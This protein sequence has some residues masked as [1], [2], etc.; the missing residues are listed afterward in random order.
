[1][2]LN[3]TL[4]D[5]AGLWIEGSTARHEH[6]AVGNDGLGVYSRTWRR[7]FVSVNG[8]PACHNAV[9][10]RNHKIEGDRT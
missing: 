4:D 2:G 8:S 9:E 5:Y 6:K 3:I 1:M 7:S 10:T